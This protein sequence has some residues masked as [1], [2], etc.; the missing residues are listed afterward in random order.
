MNGSL[1]LAGL[2][3]VVAPPLETAETPKTRLF[4]RTVPPGARE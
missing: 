4:V 2:L 1:L 3:T